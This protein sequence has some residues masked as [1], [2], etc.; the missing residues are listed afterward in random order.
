M[1]RITD[2]LDKITGNKKEAPTKV[3][4][5]TKTQQV[6]GKYFLFKT[7]SEQ[8]YLNF[9]EA[10]DETKHK[11]V[12]ISVSVQVGTFSTTEHYMVTYKKIVK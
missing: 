1:G 3:V 10:F 12:D 7:K 11:I 6:V 9:L 8:E 5:V 2:F 4:Q